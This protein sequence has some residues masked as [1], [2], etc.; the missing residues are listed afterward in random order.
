[1]ADV[2]SCSGASGSGATPGHVKVPAWDRWSSDSEPEDPPWDRDSQF[3]SLSPS[4]DPDVPDSPKTPP[5]EKQNKQKKQR[6]RR[7]KKTRTKKKSRSQRMT[8]H[9]HMAEEELRKETN[10]LGNPDADEEKKTWRRI[11][12][13][14]LTIATVQNARSTKTRTAR[15]RFAQQVE[16][17]G[18]ASAKSACRNK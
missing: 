4:R 10:Q 18:G 17:T 9:K 2:P 1:M 7:G 11:G 13:H 3:S 6:K 12:Q 16:N 8:K 15:K 14:A 5:E